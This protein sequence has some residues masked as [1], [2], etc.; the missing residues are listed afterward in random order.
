[1]PSQPFLYLPNKLRNL[2][3]H[4]SNG[5]GAVVTPKA[6]LRTPEQDKGTVQGWGAVSSV[7]RT[8]HSKPLTI[9]AVLG[10]GAGLGSIHLATLHHAPGWV[11]L[12]GEHGMTVGL[13]GGPKEACALAG[14]SPAQRQC[15]CE[16]PRPY[17]YNC[18]D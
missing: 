12:A 11:V 14:L 7:P 16:V 5:L 2:W 15:W 4:S 10:V 3:Q 18:R 17:P 9:G 13:P 8:S 1:M 6:V